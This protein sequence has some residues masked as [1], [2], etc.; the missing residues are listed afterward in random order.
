M[1]PVDGIP[2]SERSN[3]H[4]HYANASPVQNFVIQPPQMRGEAAYY[5]SGDGESAA[6]QSPISY[7]QMQF[8]VAPREDDNR[9]S[10]EKP[11]YG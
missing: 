9:R 7:Q 6:E 11:D 10:M 2:S 4:H 1:H 3:E 5:P 8:N